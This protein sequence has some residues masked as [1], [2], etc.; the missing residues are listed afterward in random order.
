LLSKALET[1]IKTISLFCKLISYFTERTKLGTFEN[2]HVLLKKIFGHQKVDVINH[3]CH[4]TRNFV[5]LSIAKTAKSNRHECAGHDWED[6]KCI[7]NFGSE[8]FS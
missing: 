3:S 1:K 7:Q 8:T 4:I 6:K 5:L 2:I